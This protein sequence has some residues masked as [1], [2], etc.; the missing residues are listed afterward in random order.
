MNRKK[1]EKKDKEF[2][3]G[4]ELFEWFYTIIIALVIAFAIKTFIFDIVEVDGPSMF[5]TLVDGDRLVVTKLGYKPEKG[6]IVILDSSYKKRNDYYEEKASSEDDNVTWFYKAKNYHSVP[7]DLKIKYYVKRVIATEGETVDIRDGYVYINGELLDEP[8][9][10]GI[11]SQIDP[12]TEF[13][14]TVDK[15]CVFVMG[16]NRPRSLDSRDS[17]LGQVPAKAVIGRS[18]FRIWPFNAIGSTK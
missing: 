4:K 1:S 17:S 6:D 13:P 15:D 12:T 3:L 2:S 9:Y 16:D 18:V 14:L 5:P 7:D 11:T 8:Y 10:D